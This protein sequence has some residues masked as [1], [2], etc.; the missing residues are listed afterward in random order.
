MRNVRVARTIAFTLCGATAAAQFPAQVGRV[1]THA[2]GA[3]G[4]TGRT[5]AIGDGG[6]QVL[7]AFGPYSD[8]TRLFSSFDQDPPTP[9]WQTTSSVPTFHHCVSAADTRDVQALLY[10]TYADQT[11]Q[12]RRV[13][14][15]RLSKSTPSLEWTYTWPV[16]TT[17][18]DNLG[19][20]VSRDGSRIVAVVHNVNTNQADVKVFSTLSSTPILQVSLSLL[21]AFR[22]MDLSADGSK[23]YIAS[24]LTHKV[25]DL[26][27]GAT[28]FSEFLFDP[29]YSAFAISG[30]GDWLAYGTVGRARVYHRSAASGQWAFDYNLDLAGPTVCDRLDISDDGSTIAC[31]FNFTDFYRTVE[32]EAADLASHQVTMT[33]IV[34]GQGA[35]QN[36]ASDVSLSADGSRFAVGLWG[37]ELGYAAEVRLYSRAQNAPLYTC[38][39]PGS[40]FDVDM[41]AS[42]DWFAVASKGS[43]A[44]LM[45]GGGRIDLFRAE[46]Q[47]L[48]LS[49]RPTA[50][51]TL[52]ARFA[53]TPGKP[54][55][56]LVAPAQSSPPVFFPS[57]GTLFLDRSSLSLLPMGPFDASGV[58][59]R[60]YTLPAAPGSV[61]CFQGFATQ[62]RRLGHDWLR[63]TVMP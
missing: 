23:L 56:L 12:T 41:S 63:L 38:D 1:W 24:G 8:Y 33:D 45:S 29:I 43:H 35:Y 9:L 49:G 30:N 13:Y 5:V 42:G 34:T 61:R 32:V 48:E 15:Q 36:V 28:L 57:I 53:G 18:G 60:T 52:T 47:D 58:A 55:V 26:N 7:T 54:A 27:T 14:V 44:N 46:A 17:G 3:E 40:P 62:P 11:L 19:V 25:L 31:L 37:D 10:D 51:A 21:T 50:G 2:S 20:R 59:T 16:L 39:L 22:G 4:W 6:S